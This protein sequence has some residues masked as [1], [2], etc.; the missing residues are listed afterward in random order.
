MSNCDEFLW[1]IST[2]C[3]DK[4]QNASQSAHLTISDLHLW[5]FDLKSH[6]LTFVPKCTSVSLAKFPQWCV[7]W[8]VHK[9]LVHERSRKYG[10]RSKAEF[11]QS[12]GYLPVMSTS[13]SRSIIHFHFFHSILKTYHLHKSFP[14]YSNDIHHFCAHWLSSVFS[15]W[16]CATA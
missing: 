9:L 14:T 3:G 11:L 7:T 1:N 6:Q 5:P 4:W 16:S 8:Q 10:H 12:S 15:V 13:L 2:Y